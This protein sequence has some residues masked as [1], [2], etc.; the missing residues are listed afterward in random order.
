MAEQDIPP[1]TITAMKSFYHL[2]REQYDILELE[3][4]TIHL[5]TTITL[6]DVI[7]YGEVHVGAPI[8]KE[9]N[10]QDVPLEVFLLLMDIRL[11]II[12][13]EIRQNIDEIDM[14]DLK[15]ILGCMKTELTIG[16]QVPNYTYQNLAFLSSK[17]TS[18][19]NEI[20]RPLL[21]PCNKHTISSQLENEGFS[22]DGWEMDLRGHW[23]L[24]AS[25]Y[26]DI[27]FSLR[28]GTQH[29]ERQDMGSAKP[30][31]HGLTTA[32]VV[33]ARG[34]V[35][36]MQSSLDHSCSRRL[37]MLTPKGISKCYS[38]ISW[39][40]NLSLLTMK[41]SMEALWLLECDLANE[42]K[43]GVIRCD[44]GTEFKNHVMNELCAKK[45][46]KKEFSVARTPQQNG[47]A[48]KKNRTLIKAARTMLADSLL[49]I[50]FWADVVNTA[51]YVL[52]RVLVTKP[53]NKT[54]YELLIGKSPSISFMRPFGCPL[55]ILNTLDSLRKFDGK[56]D[57]G[58]FLGYST[59][60][61]AF[62]VYNKRT[63]RVE[64]NMHINFLED[65]PNVTGTG[66]NWMF[67]LDF[68]TNLMN[69]IHVSVENQV[70]V[71]AG[72]DSNSKMLLQL[73]MENLLKDSLKDNDVQDSEDV[74]NKESEQDLQ[75][76]LEKMVTQELAAKAFVCNDRQ[77]VC[78]D[79]PS[80]VLYAF[81][82]TDRSNTPYVMME[83]SMELMIMMKMWVQWLISTKHMDHLTSRS[84]NQD[85]RFQYKFSFSTT[86][87]EANPRLIHKSLQDESGLKQ[88]RGIASIQNTDGLSI[89]DVI[90][91]WEKRSMIDSLMYLTA[92]RPDIMFAV[93]ACARFQVTPKASH[94]QC[95]LNDRI[96][97]DSDYRGANL[98]RKSTIGGCQFLGRRL[99]SWQCKKQTIVANSTT[100]A[101]LPMVMFS[102]S[103]L[104]FRESL[105][106]DMDGTEEFLLSNLFSFWFTKVSTDRL[107]VSTDRQS[108]YRYKAIR[109]NTEYFSGK[110]TPLFDFMLVQQIED[111]GE[112]SE[113]PFD[114]QP[115][116]S[117]PHPSED[118]PETQTAP[119]LRPYP[120]IAVLDP[121]GSGGN[122]G[123]QSSND[124]SLSGNEDGLTLQSVYDLCV[125]L[126]KHVTAQA[127]EIKDLKAQ[128]KKLKKEQKP[129]LSHNH[130]S[131][132]M[133]SWQGRLL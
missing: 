85:G 121:E 7:V 15:T 130:S 91:I 50:Q 132:G 125:S 46:I 118:Q 71:D 28:I 30:V 10:Q 47:V 36:T 38:A 107:T 17:N 133:T 23:S 29:D 6:W 127:K 78:T 123:G 49:P 5:S 4:A 57:E 31:R 40:Q 114:S 58:Y 26:V 34:P 110:V 43:E 94:L 48:E 67:D 35:F 90:C 42:V 98:D 75:D 44:N 19:T 79:R 16:L 81:V 124:A 86:S 105:E 13:E 54:P 18:S 55:T 12:H 11:P 116:P 87:L 9:D 69:Y 104:G 112:A 117:P 70:N 62:R 3:N 22:A 14:M 66:P 126:C 77:S 32:L 100:E 61:K 113:R 95:S 109:D 21:L 84:S 64:E 108:L 89:V 20:G 33:P 56:S 74:A 39:Q 63:K 93:C 24:M 82:S 51:C 83:Y 88:A 111:E 68:L 115:I 73:H 59:S 27:E 41:I 45:G 60:N 131:W 129:T 76:E 25:G 128:V 72:K 52:N 92:S 2:E 119:S 106:R 101:I 65:Q 1:P 8:S 120:S 96:F 53:Q 97:S 102:F 122:H 99:I 37:S 80:V 103:S